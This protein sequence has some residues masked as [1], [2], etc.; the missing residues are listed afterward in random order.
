[1]AL[2]SIVLLRT[3]GKR[4][5]QQPGQVS[6]PG[7][8]ALFP[9]LAQASVGRVAFPHHLCFTLTFGFTPCLGHFLLLLMFTKLTLPMLSHMTLLL[10]TT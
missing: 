3:E 9:F 7:A 10:N 2:A 1:M 5:R 8:C 6:L 4:A